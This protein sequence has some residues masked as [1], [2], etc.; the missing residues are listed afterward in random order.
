[1]ERCTR[2]R[3]ERIKRVAG[4][5]LPKQRPSATLQELLANGRLADGRRPR[6]VREPA[7]T[8]GGGPRDVVA[9]ACDDVHTSS[10]RFVLAQH[11]FNT[12]EHVRHVSD[13]VVHYCHCQ[14]KHEELTWCSA[15]TP[16]GDSSRPSGKRCPKSISNNMEH[17]LVVAFWKQ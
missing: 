14:K 13:S 4:E 12:L 8:K 5:E 2:T 7:Y 11:R 17:A 9:P 3:P 6:T 16:L 1:M 10:K 15:G